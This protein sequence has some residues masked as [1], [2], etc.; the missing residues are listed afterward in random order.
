MHSHPSYLNVACLPFAQNF[1]SLENYNELQDVRT[2]QSTPPRYI[3]AFSEVENRQKMVQ[4]G[5]RTIALAHYDWVNRRKLMDQRP[6]FGADLRKAVKV[7]LLFD[8][9]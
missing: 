8:D 2:T 4:L 5:K 9:V 1:F 3:S 6:V 7:H